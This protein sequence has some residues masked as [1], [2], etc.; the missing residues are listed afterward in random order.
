MVPEVHG[1]SSEGWTRLPRPRRIGRLDRA[2]G[3]GRFRLR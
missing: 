1:D 2:R 3:G